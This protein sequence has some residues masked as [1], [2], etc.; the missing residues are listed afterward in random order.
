VFNN[1]L[2]EAATGSSTLVN[3]GGSFNDITF[4]STA[5]LSISGG[6]A[7]NSVI[8]AGNITVGTNGT[9]IT[10]LQV[11]GNLTLNNNSTYGDITIVGN[12]TI[13]GSNNIG[14]LTMSP[15]KFLTINGGQ[16][17]TFTGTLSA[18]GNCA[19]RITI[20]SS[21]TTKA[22]ISKSSGFIAV[23]YCYLQGING[24]GGASFTAAN[25]FD[26]G[27]NSGWLI[28][29]PSAQNL[30]WVGGTGNWN[31]P[32]HWSTTSGGTGGACTPSALD[33]VFFDAN[34]FTASGQTVTVIGDANG[35]AYCRSMNWA[36]S[37]NNPTLAG[38]SDFDLN[39]YGS[40]TFIPGMTYNLSS[41]VYFKSETPGNNVF[42]AG[43]A[44]DKANIYFDGVGGEWTLQDPLSMGTRTLYLWG[45]TLNTNNHNINAGVF[46]SFDNTKTRA[47]N[48][49]SSQITLAGTGA[50]FYFRSQNFSLNAGTSHI[51]IT[52]AS[53]D[54]NHNNN[55]GPGVVFY[56]VSFEAVTSTSTLTGYGCTFNNVTFNSSGTVTGGNTIN[57]LTFAVNGT[58]SSNEN[59]INTVVVGGNAT[60]NGTGTYGH[61][62]MNGNGSITANNTFGTLIFS[63]GKQYTLT[64]GRTITILDNLIAD[65]TD[66]QIIVIKSSTV[67]SQ[68]TLSKASG[69]VEVNYVSL[70]DNNAT[71]GATF[72]ANNSI[73]LGNNT[74]WTIYTTPKDFYWVG[75]T[76]NYNDPAKWSLT[77]GGAGGAGVPTAIDNVYF[78]ANS[79][80]APGQVLTIIGDASSNAR[81][82]NMDWTGVNYNPTI[83]GAAAQNLRIHGSLILVPGITVTFAGKIYFEAT[84]TGQVVTTA[85][86]ALGTINEMYFQGDGG[87]WT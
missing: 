25:T 23:D 11:G 31:D 38:S 44:L 64:S 13:N 39:I 76:G 68:A 42:T 26:L 4:N 79:F 7:F 30:Y 36:G 51:R 2:F 48:L 35:Q 87:G 70:Q 10:T 16:T 56:N 55:T 37:L 65:G 53:A 3:A 61:F 83:A 67:N 21:T 85:G 18:N 8:A 78:D 40:L 34:S 60:I 17:Q 73:D 47:L 50:A 43:K 49:G 74:G 22:N 54:L 72:I 59:N 82:N 28:I 45:G 24:T 52:A 1:V 80:S 66:S 86:I 69:T 12:G 84:E 75:G 46:N 57:N 41:L 14:N 6:S 15:G 33:N 62:T 29:P 63:A 71:G 81:A 9:N 5:T 20:Q 19:N 27:N 32:A 58:I 77:S